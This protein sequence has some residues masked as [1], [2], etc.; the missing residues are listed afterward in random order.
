[1]ASTE[2]SVEVYFCVHIC[3]YRSGEKVEQMPEPYRS[4][5]MIVVAEMELREKK[6][7]EA[8]ERMRQK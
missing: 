1:M 7:R 3:M 4:Q 8:I 5:G 6:R 2:K